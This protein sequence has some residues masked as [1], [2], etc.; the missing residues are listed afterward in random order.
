MEKR[1]FWEFCLLSRL[2]LVLLV[3][4]VAIAVCVVRCRKATTVGQL[5]KATP[6]TSVVAQSVGSTPAKTTPAAK[7]TPAPHVNQQPPIDTK[8]RAEEKKV[9][10]VRSQSKT[11][12]EKPTKPTND[13]TVEK[14]ESKKVSKTQTW[15]SEEGILS[16]VFE[17]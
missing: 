11:E 4:G 10:P 16:S 15:E 12:V 13:K 1:E 2:G 14:A 17:K 9:A 3:S 8:E 7:S 6:P 5:P